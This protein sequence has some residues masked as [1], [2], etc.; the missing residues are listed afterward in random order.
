MN[1]VVDMLNCRGCSICNSKRTVL[2]VTVPL[3]YCFRLRT[4]RCAIWPPERAE[5]VNGGWSSILYRRNHSG[6]ATPA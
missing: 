5:E 2:T 3:H 4:R 6:F 1:S